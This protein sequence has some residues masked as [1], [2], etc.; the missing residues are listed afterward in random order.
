MISTR[1]IAFPGYEEIAVAVAFDGQGVKDMTVRGDRDVLAELKEDP[2]L[3]PV[4]LVGTRGHENRLEGLEARVR[5]G[6]TIGEERAYCGKL[7]GVVA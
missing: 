6:M 3:A 1:S 7:C 5:N 4:T 2:A